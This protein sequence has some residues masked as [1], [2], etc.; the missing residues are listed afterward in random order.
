MSWIGYGKEFSEKSVQ[1][2]TQKVFLNNNS[3]EIDFI[4]MGFEV[5]RVT[6][7]LKLVASS[8]YCRNE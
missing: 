5:M 7:R 8:N 2:L 4:S 6:Q 1:S 3:N